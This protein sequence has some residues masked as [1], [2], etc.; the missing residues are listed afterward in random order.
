MK[1]QYCGLCYTTPNLRPHGFCEKCWVAHG[2]PKSMKGLITEKD[3]EKSQ[4]V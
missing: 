2:S 3:L 4:E 1:F